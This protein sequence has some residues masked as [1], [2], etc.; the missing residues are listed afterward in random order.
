M[1]YRESV[2]LLGSEK[3]SF[4]DYFFIQ[5]PLNSIVLFRFFMKHK[6]PQLILRFSQPSHQYINNRSI[7]NRQ[8]ILTNLEFFEKIVK[9]LTKCF[10]MVVSTTKKLESNERKRR[11]KHKFRDVLGSMTFKEKTDYIWEY[12]KIHIFVGM[13]FLMAASYTVHAMSENSE[14]YVSI[15]FLGQSVSEE[16]LTAIREQI[17][18]E[19]IYEEEQ[20]SQEV[21]VQNIIYGIENDNSSIERRQQLIIWTAAGELDILITEEGIFHELQEQGFFQPLNGLDGFHTLDLNEEDFIEEE[22]MNNIYGIHLNDIEVF[23]N[24]IGEGERVIAVLVNS[25][26]QEEVMEVLQL[27]FSS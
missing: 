3:W 8:K 15:T 26:R 2:F 7:N 11:M 9:T 18:D 24:T 19:L 10:I 27:I 16:N 21:V 20:S 4:F 13:F 6:L 14:T 5:F 22:S 1:S 23:D 25:E 12:Y 17:S